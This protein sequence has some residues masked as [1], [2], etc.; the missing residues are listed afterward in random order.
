[1]ITL[2]I[3]GLMALTG[4]AAAWVTIDDDSPTEADHCPEHYSTQPKSRVDIEKYREYDEGAR[5]LTETV[6]TMK[7]FPYVDPWD[8]DEEDEDV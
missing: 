7:V 4:V 1:M 2:V 8:L 3:L 6:T 5:T